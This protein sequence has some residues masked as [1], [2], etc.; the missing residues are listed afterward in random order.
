MCVVLRIDGSVVEM[1][2][3]KDLVNG[4]DQ[5]VDDPH[6]DAGVERMLRQRDG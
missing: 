2:P 6:W 5:F 4:L 1:R 3:V